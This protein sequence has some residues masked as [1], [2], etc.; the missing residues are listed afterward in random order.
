MGDKKKIR[1]SIESF[2]KRIEEHKLKIEGYGG[3]KDYLK[4]YWEDEIKV[5]KRQK[6]EEEKKL[7]KRK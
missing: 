1:K 4:K 3:K 5:F 6:E 7:K 2:E